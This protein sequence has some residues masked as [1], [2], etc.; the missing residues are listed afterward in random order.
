MIERS[1]DRRPCGGIRAHPHFLM[2]PPWVL[3]KPVTGRASKRPSVYTALSELQ[4]VSEEDEDTPSPSNPD[5]NSSPLSPISQLKFASPEE[6]MTPTTPIEFPEPLSR[7]SS[8]PSP[9]ANPPSPGVHEEQR[10]VTPSEQLSLTTHSTSVS[11]HPPRWA[12]PRLDRLAIS[13]AI[14]AGRP[15]PELPEQVQSRPLPPRP[16]EVAAVHCWQGSGRFSYPP[17]QEFVQGSSKDPLA[18]QRP[19]SDTGPDIR[20]QSM[21]DERPKL[22]PTPEDT[23]PVFHPPTPP[24]I[25]SS[26]IATPSP[27]HSLPLPANLDP[28]PAVAVPMVFPTTSKPDYPAPILADLLSPTSID[29]FTAS[30]LTI[31]G[32]NGEKILFG[33]L[34]RDRKVVVIFIRHFLCLF[35]QDYVRSISNSVSPETLKKKGVDLVLIGNGE[36]GMIKAYKSAPSAVFHSCN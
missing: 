13:D 9:V 8:L 33:A 25:I 30:G 22:D 14:R 26:P 12:I 34:F 18:A 11:P 24:A 17:R 2:T 29:L 35:C 7:D 28:P 15:L 5:S 32:E 16:T 20:S 31:S 36:P 3:I 6:V 23:P 1:L 19:V 4:F 10:R 27:L 21:R